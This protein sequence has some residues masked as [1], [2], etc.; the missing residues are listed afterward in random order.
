VKEE[1]L[2]FGWSVVQWFSGMLFCVEGSAIYNTKLF[3]FQM[4]QEE[5]S[6]GR[7]RWD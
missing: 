7:K 6:T 4:K 1:N 5:D 2:L 3:R